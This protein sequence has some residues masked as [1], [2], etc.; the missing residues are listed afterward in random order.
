MQGALPARQQEIHDVAALAITQQP[1]T[2]LMP[3][4]FRAAHHAGLSTL[5]SSGT[6]KILGKWLRLRGLRADGT[7]FPI[8]DNGTE[9]GRVKNRRVELKDK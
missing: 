9:A 4:E 1:L 8:A 5:A 3:D 2:T 6:G 7:Q